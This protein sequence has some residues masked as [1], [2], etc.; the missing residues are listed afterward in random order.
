MAAEAAKKEDNTDFE[1]QFY[2]NILKDRP[3]FVEALRALAEI[4]TRSG[5]YQD[6]LKLDQ[7]LIEL[8]P[9]DAIAYYNLACSYSLLKDIDNSLNAIKRAVELGY[10]D[11][12]YM[13]RDPDLEN[14]R[15]DVR[16]DGI[17]PK[18]LK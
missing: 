9:D 15:E 11:F 17:L 2:E 3:D 7:R 14:L 1:I 5:R 6:G 12:S 18:D 4:Y 13:K 8:V 16:F 10:A